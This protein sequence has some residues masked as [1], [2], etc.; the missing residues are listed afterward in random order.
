MNRIQKLEAEIQKLKKQESDKKKGK[1]SISRWKMYSHGAYFLRKN[2]S[3][4]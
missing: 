2:Y 4:S 1:I 3:N